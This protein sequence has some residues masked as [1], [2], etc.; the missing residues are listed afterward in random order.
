LGYYYDLEVVVEDKDEDEVFDDEV[1]LRVEDLSEAD[2]FDWDELIVTAKYDEDK[3]R[4][5]VE[6]VLEDIKDTPTFS[7]IAEVEFADEEDDLVFKYDEDKEELRVSMDARIDEDDVEDKYEI[8]IE[9]ENDDQE[10]VYREDVD[11][12]V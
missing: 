2:D 3:E 11:V 12:V 5:Y 10:R 8:E 4:L 6:L 7:Y 9:I 1:D